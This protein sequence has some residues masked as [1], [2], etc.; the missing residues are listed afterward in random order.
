MTEQPTPSIKHLLPIALMISAAL[1]PGCSPQPTAPIVENA[2]FKEPLPGKT[3]VA[4][5]FELTNPTAQSW[6]LTGVSAAVGSSVEIHRTV[7]SGDQV[8]ME[9][10]KEIPLGPG[11]RVSFAP[12]GYHLMLFGIE[13]TPQQTEVTLHFDGDRTLT[14]AFSAE[15][16]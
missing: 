10:I 2:R 14:A 12:G 15:P 11:E 6:L 9:R 3:V 1:L 8:R 16:W 5:Y 7:R 13:Q 4:G